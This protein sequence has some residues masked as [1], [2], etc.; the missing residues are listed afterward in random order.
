MSLPGNTRALTLTRLVRTDFATYGQL[1]TEANEKLC[2]TLE[3]PYVD[4]NGDGVTDHDVSCIP[5]GTFTF[6]RRRSPKRGYDVFDTEAVPGRSAIEIHK[7]NLPSDSQ[8]CVL[9][10]T[11]FGDFGTKRGITGSAAAFDRFME[12]MAGIDTLIVTV[13]DP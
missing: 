11:A 2:V 9:V 6:R 13:V 5:S 10:G 3:R 1:S 7:G 4:A 12:R 8:G